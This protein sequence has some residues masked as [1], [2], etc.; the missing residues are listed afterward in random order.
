[1]LAGLVIGMF[2]PASVQPHAAA[3]H[4][5][6]LRYK[7]ICVHAGD[8]LSGIEQEYNTESQLDR[9]EYIA[10]V[11]SVNHI[12]DNNTVHAGAYIAVPYYEAVHA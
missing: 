1:V 2:T 3:D 9:R 12:N 10:L 7:S 11:K 5:M 6:V 4:R 8:T